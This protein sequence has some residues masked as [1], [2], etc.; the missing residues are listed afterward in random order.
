MMMRVTL[1]AIGTTDSDERE[2]PCGVAR[3]RIDSRKRVQR[4]PGQAGDRHALPQSVHEHDEH[5]AGNDFEDR[6]GM[7]AYFSS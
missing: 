6:R 3:R 7:I 5:D 2:R 1:V 4:Q